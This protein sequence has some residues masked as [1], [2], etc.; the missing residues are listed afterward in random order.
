MHVWLVTIGEPLSIAEPSRRLRTGIFADFLVEK[1]HRVTWITSRFDHYSKTYFTD[2]KRLE[3]NGIAFE[4]LDGRPYNSNISLARFA[5]HREI[6]RDFERRSGQLLRPDVIVCSFPPI[7]LADRVM[8]YAASNEIPCVID[9]RDLWPDELIARMPIPL[10]IAGPLLT[11]PMQCAVR[12]AF[13]L[14]TSI[15]GVSKTYLNWGLQHA[16]RLQGRS[17]RL[18]PLGY[19]DS[20]SALSQRSMRRLGGPSSGDTNFFFA[21]AFNNSVDLDTV[22]A[23]FSLMPERP[24]RA[25]LAGAGE[26]HAA[27]SASSAADERI[28]LPGWIDP[29]RLA[30]LAHSADVGLVCYRPESL[31][32]MPN[33][34]FEY[35]SF[36]LPILNSIPGEAAELVESNGI[37][38]NYTAGDVDSLVAC[39]KT[40][41]DNPQ[42]RREMG[43][44]SAALFE[45]RY[46]SERIYGEYADLL[47]CLTG[48][49]R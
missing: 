13:R 41:I 8:R 33:K 44:K 27:W 49:S 36:G 22:I 32:A 20:A 3:H 16:G 10:R 40:L 34:I 23:A 30:E 38:L 45:E 48:A 31:V 35:M 14:A 11:L 39:I 9:V 24:I 28:T 19:A 4:F 42:Q 18:I 2:L 26:K 12:R 46:C 29:P 17:D 15:V 43:L 5:N 25:N 47:L 1:G 37:G 6:A 7:E 21:G